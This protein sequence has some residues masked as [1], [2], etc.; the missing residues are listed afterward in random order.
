M[1][2][3]KEPKFVVG[4]SGPEIDKVLFATISQVN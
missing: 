1:I 3:M 4:F 2:G